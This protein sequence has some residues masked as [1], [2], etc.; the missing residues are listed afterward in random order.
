MLVTYL[1]W[2]VEVIVLDIVAMLQH[3]HCT[4]LSCDRIAELTLQHSTYI[5]Q[6]ANGNSVQIVKYFIRNLLDHFAIVHDI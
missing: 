4:F 1:L 3:L 5:H 6:F 2:Q